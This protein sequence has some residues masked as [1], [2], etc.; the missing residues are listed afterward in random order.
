MGQGQGRRGFG[1][2]QPGLHQAH[3]LWPRDHM[4]MHQVTCWGSWKH[5]LVMLFSEDIFP[6]ELS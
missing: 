6:C 3:L 5:R 4:G 1:I 2:R